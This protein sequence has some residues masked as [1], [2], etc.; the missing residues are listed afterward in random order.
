MP[1]P[2]TDPT[3]GVHRLAFAWGDPHVNVIA[4]SLE[5]LEQV[6]GALRCRVMF[7][8][9]T[10]TQTLM[11]LDARAVIAVAPA[12][13]TLEAAEDL[14]GVRAFV[15]EPLEAIVLHRGTWHWGPYPLGARSVRL[16]NVQG[17]GYREDNRHVDLA[18]AGLAFDI[19]TDSEEVPDGTR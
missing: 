6:P 5:E 17:F 11:S 18:A 4:H 14:E 15:L 19:P 13:D 3:D 10:H 12:D 8:H 9:D 16:F 7:R 2:D 1:V